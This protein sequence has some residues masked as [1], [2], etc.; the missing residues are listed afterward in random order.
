MFPYNWLRPCLQLY[1]CSISSSA[2]SW[3]FHSL[4]EPVA[5]K[6]ILQQTLCTK[7]ST[8]ESVFLRNTTKERLPQHCTVY[9]LYFKVY[10]AF[11]T[12]PHSHH[13][14]RSKM[15]SIIP[16]LEMIKLNFKEFKLVISQKHRKHEL[17]IY[18]PS[19][20]RRN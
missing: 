12:S 16:T 7:I 14:S 8:S 6:S 1:P 17:L 11:V 20:F 10:R 9:I 19:H 3:L 13:N 4:T 5:K 2:Q 18:I 15:T